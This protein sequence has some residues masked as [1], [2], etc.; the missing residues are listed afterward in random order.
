MSTAVRRPSLDVLLRRADQGALDEPAFDFTTPIDCTRWFVCPTLTPLYYAPVYRDLSEDQRRRY[1]QLTAMSF[2]ELIAFFEGTFAASVLAALSAAGGRQNQAEP[3]DTALAT[4][5]SGFLADERKHIGWW[6]EL[7]RLSDPEL[8]AHMEQRIIRVPAVTRRLLATMTSRPGTFPVV[9][10]IML[11]LEERS[12]DISRRTMQMD[13]A[14]LEPRYRLIYREH[15]KDEARHV[16]IDGHL[17]E[18][19]YAGRSRAVRKWNAWLLSVV[20][21]KFLLPPTRSAVRV[22]RRLACEYPE[23]ATLVPRMIAELH[24]VGR[25]PE[26]HAMMYSRGT[27]PTLFALFDQFAELHGMRRVLS[28]YTPNA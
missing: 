8:Y 27:T 16:Q 17:I 23:I 1:N 20:I 10:W 22:A 11:A 3:A 13:S 24:E 5:L 19:F 12:L 28:S 21:G 14:V 7:N 4:C 9:Y 15:L 2:S 26:Y 25:N 18:R 6:R